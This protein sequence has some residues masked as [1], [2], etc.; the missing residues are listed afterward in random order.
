M[1]GKI[2]VFEGPDHCGKTTLINGIY[3]KLKEDFKD[4]KIII[5]R[6]PGGLNDNITESIR[7]MLLDNNN[8]IDPITE[9]YLFAAS[10]VRHVNLLNK[11]LKDDDT[12]IL[13]DRFFYSSLVYQ[14]NSSIS[15]DEL[16]KLNKFA[17]EGLKIDLL[18]ILN[19]NKIEDYISRKG[20]MESL[21]RIESR[22]IDYFKNIIEHYNAIFRGKRF[23][24]N[25]KFLLDA[26]KPKEEVLNL[27]YN[28]IFNII[29][30]EQ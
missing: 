8:I 18:F 25:R 10:R 5:T 30:E 26:M 6:E 19:F 29:K 12:I 24:E 17:I 23:N 13:C 28:T 9:A 4:K 20:N 14:H 3:E 1:S 2:F 22:D 11:L 27:V 16:V 21:D 7:N 15:Y